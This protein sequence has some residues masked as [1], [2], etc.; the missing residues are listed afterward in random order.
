MIPGTL[1][2]IVSL[3]LQVWA[4]CIQDFAAGPWW[5]SSH[6]VFHGRT[7]FLV[8]K[9]TWTT[10]QLPKRNKFIYLAIVMLVTLIHLSTHE[11]LE[12]LACYFQIYYLYILHKTG[13]SV[14]R[15][16]MQTSFLH[17][18]MSALPNSIE[19]YLMNGSFSPVF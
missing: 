18:S 14:H 10:V 1:R 12:I 15:H 13:S 8:A 5:H 4:L 2:H 9:L 11:D 3:P 6:P 17:S 19:K 7:S 16:S